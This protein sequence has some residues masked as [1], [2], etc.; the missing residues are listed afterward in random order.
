MRVRRHRAAA[1]RA[2]RI[3][4]GIICTNR[5]RKQSST[6]CC[7]VMLRRWYIRPCWKIWRASNGMRM[8]QMQAE[9]NI[10]QCIGAVIDVEFEGAPLPKIYDALILEGSDLVL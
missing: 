7:R 8:K 10:V 5:T 4:N 6:H 1:K 9:G 3:T 2:S